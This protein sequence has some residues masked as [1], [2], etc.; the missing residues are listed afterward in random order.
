MSEQLTKDHS[1]RRWVISKVVEQFDDRY[2]IATDIYTGPTEN[3]VRLTSVNIVLTK[4]ALV[5]GG[6]SRPPLTYKVTFENVKDPEAVANKVVTALLM[7]EEGN[8]T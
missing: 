3:N 8:D 6:K 5:R 2:L 7:M 1:T 4:K